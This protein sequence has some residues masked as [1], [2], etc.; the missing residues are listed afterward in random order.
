[1]T[2][3]KFEQ[4]SEALKYFA[5]AT[6]E[7]P[8]TWFEGTEISYSELDQRVTNFARALIAS[9]INK[10]DRVVV[11]STPRPEFWIAALAIMRSGAIYTGINPSYTPREQAHVVSNCEPVLIFSLAANAGRSYVEEIE[12]LLNNSTLREAVRLDNGDAAGALG[13]MADFLSRAT[14]QSLPEVSPRDPGAIVYTSGSTGAPK[15]A[16][17][18]HFALAYGAYC[19]AD[20]MLV[21][22]PRVP[23]NLPTNHTGCIVDVC[24]A[25]LVEG[26]MLAFI[27]KFDAGDILRLIEELKLTNLQHVP[28]VLQLV[29]LH[30]DFAKTD[31]SSLQIVAWGGAALPIEF[32]NI[33]KNLGVKLLTTFGQTETVGNAAW[34]HLSDSPEQLANSVGHAN[35][36]AEVLLVDEDGNEVEPGTEGEVWYRHP[37]IFLRYW[38]NPEATKKTITEDGF[39]K[40]GDVAVQNPDGTLRLVGRRSEMFKSGGLNVYPREVELVL[41]AHEDVALAAV[42]GLKNEQWG[43]IGAAYVVLHENSIASEDDLLKWCRSNLAGYKIP[44]ILRIEAELPFLPIGK[45]DKNALRDRLAQSLK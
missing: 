19:D 13:S 4:F 32:V 6:P 5:S 31:L 36:D 40:M 34:S 2:N 17:I 44:K 26:G 43:E 28:T 23:C 12:V 27:E 9:G 24:G 3:K 37:A 35:P 15:G 11:L 41:E 14:N 18:P 42:F 38:N 20:A 33:Y 16:L 39:L 45:V 21:S 22:R 8:A 30:P 1:V 10:G 25:T 7:A 29:A